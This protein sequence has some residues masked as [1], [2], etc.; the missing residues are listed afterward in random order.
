MHNQEEALLQIIANTEKVLNQI[1][2]GD[3]S[4]AVSFAGGDSQTTILRSL[5]NMRTHLA[6]L[7]GEVSVNSRQMLVSSDN[8]TGLASTTLKRASSIDSHSAEVARATADMNLNMHTIASAAE[9]LSVNM[10]TVSSRT[11]HSSANLANVTDA[12]GQMTATIDEIARNSEQARSIVDEAVQSVKRTSEIMNQLGRAASGINYVTASISGISDQ[13]KLL[14]LNAT[15]EAARAGEAGSRFRVVANEVKALAGETGKATKDIQD[16]VETMQ[17]AADNALGEI[18]RINDVIEKVNMVVAVIATAVEQQ[19]ATTR[20][21]AANINQAASGFQD[22]TRAVTEANIAVQEVTTNITHVAQLSGEIADQI[23]RVSADNVALREDA[24]VLYA[25][26]ME[27]GSRAVDGNRIVNTFKIPANMTKD[28]GGKNDLFRFSDFYSVQVKE[29]DEQHRMIFDFINRVHAAIKRRAKRQELI[30]I[31]RDMADFTAK[32]FA[33]E[34]RL[35]KAARFSALESHKPIHAKLLKDLGD[36]LRRLE[37]NE[38]V[39]LIE[40][41]VFLKDWLVNHI[42]GTDKKYSGSMNNA[43]IR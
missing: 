35:M 16:K 10:S 13:T 21:I 7:I 42:Q 36:A 15:I 39:N 11:E 1:E 22:M 34:E 23:N 25:E 24:T 19:S 3:L 5:E 18:A 8:L 41:M 31:L 9:E 27:V 28:S 26:A 43:G 33:N 4:A 17:R 37:N 38:D 20:E 2:T 30:P 32:H 29:L 40:L 6:R 12:V 14:A